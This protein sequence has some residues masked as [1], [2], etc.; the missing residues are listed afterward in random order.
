[1]NPGRDG[2]PRLQSNSRATDTAAL[3]IFSDYG[4]NHRTNN[5]PGH[6]I[7]EPMNGHRD[8]HADIKRVEDCQYTQPPLFGIKG[9][10]RCRHG[11]GYGGMRR[12]PAP[13]N[14]TTQ[15]TKVEHVTDVRANVMQRMGAT[16][17]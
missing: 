8:A 10:H 1:M 5:R 14:A 17:K 15:E 11:K 4:T 7:R 13:E 3:P 2:V 16:G 6:E 9:E 12:R